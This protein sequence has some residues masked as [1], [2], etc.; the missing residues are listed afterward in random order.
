M[1]DDLTV[2]SQCGKSFKNVLIHWSK[3]SS[4]DRPEPDTYEQ[5]LIIGLWLTGV[6]LQE[7]ENSKYPCLVKYSTNYD[8]LKWIADELGFWVKDSKVMEM[9]SAEAQTEHL[10]E[11]FGGDHQASTLYAVRVRPSLF[12]KELED[13]SP[14]DITLTSDS[15]RLLYAFRGR[16][17]KR[18]REIMF[19][20][21]EADDLAELLTRNGFE[22]ASHPIPEYSIR[23]VRMYVDSARRFAEWI[24]LDEPLPGCE[25][26]FAR[27]QA[28]ISS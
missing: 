1:S 8:L 16:I 27:L 5:Q 21:P 3:S 13:A 17:E 10:Q 9:R 6:N 19:N 12:I 26:K 4:C 14:L 15:A 11:E 7:N 24:V 22:A 18:E 25:K 2:C 28:L 20:H 23:R